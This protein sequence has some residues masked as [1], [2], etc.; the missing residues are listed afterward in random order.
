MSMLENVYDLSSE[1]ATRQKIVQDSVQERRRLIGPTS[2]ITY[3]RRVLSWV[4]KTFSRG[5]MSK[6]WERYAGK[7]LNPQTHH[8]QSLHRF[9]RS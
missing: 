8:E 5:Q 7:H 4:V 9:L 2:G 1:P 6:E 3:H